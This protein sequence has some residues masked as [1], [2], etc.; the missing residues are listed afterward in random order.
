MRYSI[1]VCASIFLG[2]SALASVAHADD[3]CA[4]FTWNVAHERALFGQQA[5]VV[6]AGQ[7]TGAA[8][9]LVTD[10]LYQVELKEQSAVIFAAAPGR[11]SATTGAYAGLARFTTDT[12]GVYRIALDQTVWVDVVVDGSLVQ[13]RDFQGRPGC[14]AP[15]K[16]VEF[17]LPTKASIT[18]QFSGGTT[19]TLKVTV[20]RAPPATTSHPGPMRAWTAALP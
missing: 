10:G 9:R 6:S 2:F 19:A 4:A 13:S 16:I 1:S 15:H 8:P 3:P 12:G 18:L 14:N 7:T 5:H 20:T 17:L 11:K